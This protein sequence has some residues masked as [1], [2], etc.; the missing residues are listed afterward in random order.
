MEEELQLR[1]GRG[2]REESEEVDVWGGEEREEQFVSSPRETR[3]VG[4][5]AA[6]LLGD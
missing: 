6:P 1:E 2:E 5:G 3:G 4:D